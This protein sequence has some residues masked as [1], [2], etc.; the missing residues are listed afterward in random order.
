MMHKFFAKLWDD[1]ES[2]QDLTEY[3]LLIVLI[4]LAATAALTA[5]GGAVSTGF[6]DA[7]AEVSGQV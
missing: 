6:Q 3:V 4:S 1:D 7:A 2:G 5:L